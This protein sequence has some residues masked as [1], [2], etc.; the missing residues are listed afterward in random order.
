MSNQPQNELAPPEIHS[1]PSTNLRDISKSA[2]LAHQPVSLALVHL[3][4]WSTHTHNIS[5]ELHVQAEAAL[6]AALVTSLQRCSPKDDIF[7][8]TPHR[9]QREAVKAALSKIRLRKTAMKRL[10]IGEEAVC[11][12]VTVDTIE[13]L[14]GE[15]LQSSSLLDDTNDTLI[16]LQDQKPHS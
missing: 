1:K 15:V 3:R 9:I 8:A 10:Q 5:Y 7:V 6:A 2:T 4:T 12:K 13:R 11:P 16:M 14:Q